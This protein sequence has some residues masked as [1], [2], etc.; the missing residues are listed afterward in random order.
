MIRFLAAALVAL[1][2]AACAPSAK[3]NADDPF[4]T[5]QPWNSKWSQVKR[6]TPEGK[7]VVKDLLTPVQFIAEDAPELAGG[8]FMQAELR[9]T[10]GANAGTTSIVSMQRDSAFEI[11]EQPAQPVAAG[12][13]FEVTGKTIEYIVLKKGDGSGP[14]PGRTDQVTVMYDGRLA[15]NGTQFDSSYLRGEPATFVLNQVIA[16]WTEGLQEMRAGDEFMFWIPSPLGYGE[17]GAGS[18]IP[19]DA[20]LMFRVELQKV[21]PAATSDAAAWAKITPW[22]TDSGDVMRTATGL[23]YLVIQKGDAAEEPAG[24]QDYAVVHFRG[25]LEDGSEVASTF[26]SQQ[27]QIFPIEQLVAGWAE[28]LQ[29][30]RP[31][32]RWMVRMPAALMYGEEGDGRIPPSASVVFEILVN[33]VIRIPAA[34]AAAPADAAPAAPP[35]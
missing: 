28:T 11:A 19:A 17:N 27:P 13:A 34:D 8:R 26:E 29:M 21:T 33:E 15:S 5:L 16:G 12:D 31:G 25:Q 9:W 10:K 6:I 35:Q 3:I 32:D 14:K 24:P 4:A 22:P 30:M 20:D 18:D 1:F 2:V 23:E 7:G